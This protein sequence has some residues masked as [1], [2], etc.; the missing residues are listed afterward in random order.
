MAHAP[1]YL[2]LSEPRGHGPEVTV[3]VKLVIDTPRKALAFAW[4]TARDAAFLAWWYRAAIFFALLGWGLGRVLTGCRALP[5]L[6]ALAI[7]AVATTAYAAGELPG[8]DDWNTKALATSCVV[9]LLAVAFLGRSL[10]ASYEKR[11]EEMGRAHAQTLE[12]H[13]NVVKLGL[14]TTEAVAVLGEAV[15]HV[16]RSDS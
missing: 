4:D 15:D 7:S 9:L 1:A 8:V 3:T 12:T 16:T 5:L 14:Q 10:L 13:S 11:L 2:E 6:L